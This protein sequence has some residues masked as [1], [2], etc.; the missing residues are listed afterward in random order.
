MRSGLPIRTIIVDDEVLARRKI[1][2]LLQPHRDFQVIAECSAGSEAVTQIL[3]LKPD[4]LFLDIRIP[5]MDG[6]EVLRKL[7]RSRC[8][9]SSS[10]RRTMSTPFELSR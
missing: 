10:R 7:S 4:L 3:E 1:R 8:G 5:E 6:F 9:T 2:A